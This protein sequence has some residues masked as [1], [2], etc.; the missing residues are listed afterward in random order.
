M[1]L[2]TGKI[3][4]QA[5]FLNGGNATEY[6][7]YA[8]GASGIKEAL[9][10]IDNIS[11]RI[12][13]GY[14]E[15]AIIY[16]AGGETQGVSWPWKW[17][18][19]NYPKAVPYYTPDSTIINADVIVAD[20]QSYDDITALTGDNYYYIDTL[21]MVWPNQDYFSLSWN[22]IKKV[23]VDQQYRNAV[24]QMWLRRD[25]SLYGLITDKT[26][27][28]IQHWSPSDGIRLYVQKSAAAKLWEYDLLQQ[29]NLV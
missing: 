20:P 4:V 5:S 2:I 26:N 12:S 9:S 16:D 24:F 15:L 22:T 10:Q 28:D 21:R 29:R 19:R 25:F 23:L 6:L 8:H 13:G 14:N 17:Y 7:V 3:S 11:K 18:M 1:A 27:L